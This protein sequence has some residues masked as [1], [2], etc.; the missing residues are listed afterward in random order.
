MVLYHKWDVKNDFAY[1]LQ[2]FLLIS[3]SLGSVTYNSLISSLNNFI[4]EQ[5]FPV[6]KQ[7]LSG[8]EMSRGVDSF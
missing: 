8:S 7:A 1:V 5:S 4:H 3:D 2:F 6:Y